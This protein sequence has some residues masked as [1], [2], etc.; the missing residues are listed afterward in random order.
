MLYKIN[1]QDMDILKKNT[2]TMD[3]GGLLYYFFEGR[4]EG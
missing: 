2:G 1:S 4:G 3:G